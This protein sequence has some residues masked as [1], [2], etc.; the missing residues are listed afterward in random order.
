MPLETPKSFLGLPAELRNKIYRLILVQGAEPKMSGPNPCRYDVPGAIVLALRHPSP[1]NGPIAL[2]RMENRDPEA[3]YQGGL[4]LLRANPTIYNE[5]LPILY[6]ENFFFIRISNFHVRSDAKTFLEMISLEARECL[7]DL[8][9]ESYAFESML[10]YGLPCGP[11]LKEWSDT[12]PSELTVRQ[13]ERQKMGRDLENRVP[14][15]FQMTVFQHK[16]FPEQLYQKTNGGTRKK[17][18]LD[19]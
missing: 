8:A 9:L 18:I 5:A 13:V 1:D 7:R 12:A 16:M 11:L 10:V 17:H 14:Y 4:T 6:G 19:R 15:S 2:L 3:H